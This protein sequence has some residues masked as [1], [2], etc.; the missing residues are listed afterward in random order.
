MKFVI[1]T[2]RLKAIQ[3][4]SLLNFFL[5]SMPDNLYQSKKL[6]AKQKVGKT[7]L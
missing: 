3:R 1:T 7:H 2:N 5:K 4:N 6:F